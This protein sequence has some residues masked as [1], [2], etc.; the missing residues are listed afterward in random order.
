MSQTLAPA[1]TPKMAGVVDR[2]ARAHQP[3]FH[4]LTPAEAKAAY[5]KG[6]GVLEVPKPQLERVEDFTLPARDGHALPARL[7]AP[8]RAVL[9]LLLFFHG[10]GFTVGSIATHDTLCRVLSQKSGSAVIS[11]DYRLAPE[12][13]FPAASNDAWD[14]LQFVARQAGELGLDGT[15]IAVGGDSAGGTLAAVCAILARDA[16]LPLALQMLFYPGTTSHQDTASHQRFAAG[17][18]LDE[19]LVSWFFAQYLST[20][21]ER[22]DWRFAPL[23]ADDVEGVAPAWIGLAECDPVVDEGIAYADKLRAAGVA[24]ELEIY[25]GVIHEFVKMGRAIPEALQA[26]ADAARALKEALNP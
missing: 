7:Y 26:H 16:G 1:L 3:P 13:K 15:R 20:P 9:P 5:E 14:A 8:S 17:P 12:H 10:G 24:V 18:L 2:M 21:A 11:L 19:P 23:N 6:A 25:R 4:T 22:E